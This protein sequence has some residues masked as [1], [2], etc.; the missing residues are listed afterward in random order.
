MILAEQVIQTLSDW[1]SLQ[2]TPHWSEWSIS[3][4]L[5]TNSKELVRANLLYATVI[6]FCYSAYSEITTDEQR[7]Q[8]KKQFDVT[9]AVYKNLRAE[10]DDISDQM[11]ELSQELDTL[12]EEST[13]FQVCHQIFQIKG[14][15]MVLWLNDSCNH[16]IP[17]KLL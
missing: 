16:S 5:M 13:K 3:L 2:L 8:Y 6:I 11:N 4:H 12:H 15:L 10:L 14:S 17:Q 9:F 1:L 7:R